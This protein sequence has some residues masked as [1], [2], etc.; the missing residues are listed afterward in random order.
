MI[1]VLADREKL[2]RMGFT[3]SRP[4][5]VSEDSRCH[6][7]EQD[8]WAAEVGDLVVQILRMRTRSALPWMRGCP[9]MWV[10]VAHG[11]EEEQ[12]QRRTQKKKG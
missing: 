7:A 5:V 12:G 3:L 10:L 4:G 9:E 1:L 6:A 2:A 11:S 8:S